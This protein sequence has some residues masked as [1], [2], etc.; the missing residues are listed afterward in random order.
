MSS[1][2]VLD[3]SHSVASG[4]GYP[5][6]STKL[7]ALCDRVNMTALGLCITCLQVIAEDG[8]PAKCSHQQQLERWVESDP[9]I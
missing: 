3:C 2:A 4:T 8:Q 9:F 7:K 5:V 6:T 1:L